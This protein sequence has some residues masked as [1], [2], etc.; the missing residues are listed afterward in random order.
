M[1]H[2]ARNIELKARL[3]DPSGAIKI[4]QS[5]STEPPEKQHQIDTYFKSPY[6]RLKL[7]EVF[8]QTAQLVWYARADQASAKGSDYRLVPVGE[9]ESLK[10]ALASAMGVLVVVDKQR[11][12]FL[13]GNVRIHIDEVAELGSFIEFEAVLGPTIDDAAGRAQV[14]FLQTAFQLHAADLIEHSY[15]DMMPR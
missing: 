10:R 6:G 5:L 12:V 7:R 11:L 4:A 13:Y 3:S 15:S 2:A 8:G 9:P 1:S 14:E